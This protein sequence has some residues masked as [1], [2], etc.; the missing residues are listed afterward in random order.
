MTEMPAPKP[1]PAPPK[2][3]DR[4]LEFWRGVV[5]SYSL[6]IDELYVLECACREIDLI[7]Q[8]AEQQKREDLIGIGSM[9]QPVVAPLIP[10]LRQH[11]ST[12]AALVK[13]LKLPDSTGAAVLSPTEKARHAA[14]VR[15][16]NI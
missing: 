11:R 9:G 2:L 4:A 5:S 7:D 12:L 15:W 14:N 10:E 3:S 16:K 8:M 6:R 13:Q 1:P